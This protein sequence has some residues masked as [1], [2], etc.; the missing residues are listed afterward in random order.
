MLP[1]DARLANNAKRSI[2]LMRHRSGSDWQVGILTL[3]L[4]RLRSGSQ[5]AS[6]SAVGTRPTSFFRLRCPAGAA[7]M[8]ILR[9]T[10]SHWLTH[11]GRALRTRPDRWSC[12]VTYQIGHYL[13]RASLLL[14]TSVPAPVPH[15]MVRLVWYGPG[16]APLCA[17]SPLV[18]SACVPCLNL[19]HYITPR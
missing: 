3:F 10:G 16:A 7:V 4:H 17:S 19:V 15:R 11:L 18:T 9:S 13:E 1:V 14:C 8:L 5:P 12:Q 2:R 6:L